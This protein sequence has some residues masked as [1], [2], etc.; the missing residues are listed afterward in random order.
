MWLSRCSVP[1]VIDDAS[2]VAVTCES[3]RFSPVTISP[4]KV[5]KLPR[6]L[7]TIMCRTLKP[8]VEW[9][10]SMSQVPAR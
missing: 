4:E 7:L 1:V 10:A 9:E 6:T 3:S 5:W 8:T 2:T